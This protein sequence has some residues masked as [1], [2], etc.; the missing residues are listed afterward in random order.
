MEIYFQ[1]IRLIIKKIADNLFSEIENSNGPSFVCPS[2]DDASRLLHFTGSKAPSS[3][4]ADLFLEVASP[5]YND[6]TSSL[7]FS[8]K[9]ELG[10]LPTLLNA[11]ATKFQ[12]RIED[13]SADKAF[14]VEE[15][16]P[17]LQKKKLIC[18]FKIANLLII[19]SSKHI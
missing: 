4:K 13:C 3:E 2:T 10:G 5:V 19:S 16:I 8:I 6:E 1:H 18:Q 9:S 12:Y 7:G 14:L 15:E 17:R 11:G